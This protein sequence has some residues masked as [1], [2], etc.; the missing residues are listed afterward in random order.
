MDW[1]LRALL[2]WR[3]SWY[4]VSQRYLC[5]RIDNEREAAQPGSEL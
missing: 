1:L 4:L 2:R 3:F 5:A